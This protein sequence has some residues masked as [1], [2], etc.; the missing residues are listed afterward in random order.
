MQQNVSVKLTIPHNIQKQFS[1]IKRLFTEG[2]WYFQTTNKSN[3]KDECV[4]VSVCGIV[5]Y[6]LDLYIV[7]YL[8]Y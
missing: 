2:V 8:S 7:T 4:C 1:E 3:S 5:L 6:Y